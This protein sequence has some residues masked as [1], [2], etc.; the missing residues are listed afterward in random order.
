MSCGK[1]KAKS[2]ETKSLCAKKACIENL[3]VRNL[4][5]TPNIV[6][7]R[8]CGR[9]I[10]GPNTNT[11]PAARLVRYPGDIDDPDFITTNAI[12]TY[13]VVAPAVVVSGGVPV[14]VNGAG[15]NPRNGSLHFA[16]VSEFGL[17]A[18]NKSETRP[19]GYLT[20]HLL[21]QLGPVGQSE[22]DRV[23]DREGQAL[24]NELWNQLNRNINNANR[25][26]A[27]TRVELLNE[28]RIS[29]QPGSFTLP[30]RQYIIN[31]LNGSTAVARTDPFLD[32]AFA[33]NFLSLDNYRHPN[34]STFVF[35]I[36]F[37]NVATI[38]SGIVAPATLADTFVYDASASAIWSPGIALEAGTN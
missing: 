12:G 1:I 24:T 18:A 23:I 6:E 11:T 21:L 31:A 29:N 14:A 9:A 20:T 32:V 16:D 28:E 35:A 33:Q 19:A 36:Q 38:Q 2:I 17:T 27:L 4:H 8:I 5:T 25:G 13:V 15:L 22:E 30:Q 26:K 37:A 3:Y 7:R 34:L 10:G